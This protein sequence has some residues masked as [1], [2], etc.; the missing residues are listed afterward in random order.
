MARSRGSRRIASRARSSGGSFA[1]GALAGVAAGVGA[2]FIGP[3]WGP[4]A[5][6][7]AVGA[8]RHDPTLKV[9]AGV[10]IGTKLAAMLPGGLAGSVG[11]GGVL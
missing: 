3:Q 5:G 4:A 9:L 6:L 10:A 2:N 1:S 8:F 7:A 11:P